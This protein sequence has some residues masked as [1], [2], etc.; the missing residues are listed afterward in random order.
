MYKPQCTSSFIGSGKS[1]QVYD[2][3][4]E[5]NNLIGKICGSSAPMAMR[6]CKQ[7]TMHVRFKIDSSTAFDGFKANW[8][9][10]Y[11]LLLNKRVRWTWVAHLGGIYSLKVKLATSMATYLV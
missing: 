9:V 1:F 6:S 4:P 8:H 10:S 5:S 7:N 2:G 3:A 11:L